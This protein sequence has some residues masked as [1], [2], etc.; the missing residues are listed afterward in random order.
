MY[1]IF[2]HECFYLST[3][4][5]YHMIYLTKYLHMYNENDDDILI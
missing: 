5:K 3:Q 4:Y 1:L 2:E